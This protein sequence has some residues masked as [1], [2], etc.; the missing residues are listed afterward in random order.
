[1]VEKGVGRQGHAD[2]S[3]GGDDAALDHPA[4]VHELLLDR[5]LDEHP[6]GLD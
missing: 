6:P 2:V 5:E 1:V 4:R 3:V